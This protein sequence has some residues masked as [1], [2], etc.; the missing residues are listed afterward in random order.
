MSV[1]NCCRYI[2][3]VGRA[4]DVCDILVPAFLRVGLVFSSEFFFVLPCLA[5]PCAGLALAAAVVI[6]GG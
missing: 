1:R 2:T 5:L 4:V 6:F 3:A